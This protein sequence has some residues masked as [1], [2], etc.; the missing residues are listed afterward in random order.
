[1]A[2]EES[3]VD[4][5]PPKRTLGDYGPQ[6]GPRY[7]SS[8]VAPQPSRALEM[9]PAFITL[10]SSHQFSGLDHE[11]PYAHLSN[12][13]DLCGTMG[14]PEGD[15][16]VVYLRL[17][18]FTLQ[19]RA[20]TWLQTHPNQSLTSWRDVEDK[21]VNRF[22]PSSKYIN[23][24]S[25]I[26]TF[27]QGIDESFC[28]AWE[29]FKALLRKCP[30]H[31]FEDIAQLNFFCNGIK[32]E[33]KMLLDAAAGG[34]MMS[35]GPDEATKIIDS[36]ASSDHQAQHN[37]QHS[38]RKSMLELNSNDTI[39]AQNKILSQQIETLTKEIAKLKP[40]TRPVRAVSS[41]QK[42]LRC[43]FCGGDHLN[44]HCDDHAQQEEVQYM[45]QPQQQSMQ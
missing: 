2:E 37:R 39:L 14:I 31:G 27:R 8:I 25:E 35:M 43:D 33:E 24:K 36:F 7:F 41:S 1:M 17:F 13:Y 40:P 6:Q 20:K 15:E 32:P 34:T 5:S 44:G 18:P 10:I 9:K 29:R 16:E 45:G 23:A 19:G 38:S 21:F 11:D 12:F 26:T 42:V 4:P 3:H 22:Y 28:E 30:H